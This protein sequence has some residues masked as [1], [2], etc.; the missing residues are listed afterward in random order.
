[1]SDDITFNQTECLI[2]VEWTKHLQSTSFIT[3]PYLQEYAN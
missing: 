3:G 1:M 2:A